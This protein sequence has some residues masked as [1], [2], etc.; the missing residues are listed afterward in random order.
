MDDRNL[1]DYLNSHLA[2]SVAG[3]E[4]ARR[5]VKT[6]SGAP[7]EDFVVRLLVELEEDQEMV[8]RLLKAIDVTEE[9]LKS[10]GSWVMEK[11]GVVKIREAE[12]RDVSYAR[13]LEMEGLLVGTRGRI[14]LWTV[15]ESCIPADPRLS[16]ADFGFLRSRAEGHA[17]MLEKLRTAAARD[18]F[19]R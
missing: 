11:L 4:L 7:E 18:A 17:D 2:G 8:R 1:G 15:M 6:Y 12:A 16:F 13:M 14:A 19:R 3:I 10:I 5:A 9:T